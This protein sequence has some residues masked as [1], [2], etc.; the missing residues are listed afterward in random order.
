MSPLSLF[1]S[2]ADRTVPLSE[3]EGEGRIVFLPLMLGLAVNVVSLFIG[4]PFLVLP[5]VGAVALWITIVWREKTLSWILF[6]SVMAA[7]P[8]NY[9]TTLSLNLLFGIC[10]LGIGVELSTAVPKWMIAPLVVAFVS[11]LLS[12]VNW[13]FVPTKFGPPFQAVSAINYVVGP[14]FLMPLAY[15]GMRKNSDSLAGLRALPIYLILPTTVVL[16]LAYYLGTPVSSHTVD[17]S[18]PSAGLTLQFGNT[19]FNFVRT[20]IGP[21]LACC[22]CASSA[23]LICRV[24]VPYK[25]VAGLLLGANFLFLL[26]TG[27]VGSGVACALA[28]LLIAFLSFR[29]LASFRLL[30]FL[31]GAVVVMVLVWSLVPDVVRDYAGERYRTRLADGPDASDRTALWSDAFDFLLQHPEGIGWSGFLYDPQR[32]YP[33]NDYLTYGIALGALGGLVYIYVLFRLLMS[34]LRIPESGES[35]HRYGL[36]LAGIGVL[37]VIIVN[38][39]FDHLSANKWYFNVMWSIVWYVYY[40]CQ[41]LTDE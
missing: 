19:L 27:S 28:L 37:A 39:L 26:V 38:S 4:N 20:Q 29:W 5:F 36:R 18:V 31:A 12:S 6:A 34:L 11:L 7:N 21:L 17:P 2:T 40:S 32:G 16:S 25:V 13:L 24:G 30:F 3:D 41:P 8:A 15:S 22:I 14:F 1:S 10:L 35:E 23:V 9:A 33:H